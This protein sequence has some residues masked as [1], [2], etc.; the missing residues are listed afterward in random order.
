[1][2]ENAGHMLEAVASAGYVVI[3]HTS[4]ENF[5]CHSTVD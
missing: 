4:G 1:M 5:Y 2:I 3:A